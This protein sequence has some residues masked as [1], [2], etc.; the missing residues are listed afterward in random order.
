MA[1]VRKTR[2]EIGEPAMVMGCGLLGQIAVKELRAAG[3]VPII[4]ADPVEERRKLALASGADY[5]LDPLQ[6]DFAEKARRLT[7]GG[8]KAV[9]EVTGVGAGL[10]EALDATARFGRVALLGCTR[11]KEFTID[12]YR[13]VHCPGITLI[14]AHTDARS[15]LESRPGMFTT[16]G[17]IKTMISLLETGRLSFDSFPREEYEPSRC[18]EAYQRLINDRNFPFLTQFNWSRMET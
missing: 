9:I 12:Y 3:A 6:P 8:A 4:A 17:D 14:G 1:A 18:A 15:E 5:A 13:K 2:L 16:R 10:D 11:N 7:G